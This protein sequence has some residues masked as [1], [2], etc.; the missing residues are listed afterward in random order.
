[1]A[2]VKGDGDAQVAKGVKKLITSTGHKKLERKT[3]GEPALLEGRPRS[4]Q[5]R[6]SF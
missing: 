1:M 6:R 3:D 4:I 2:D 5:R